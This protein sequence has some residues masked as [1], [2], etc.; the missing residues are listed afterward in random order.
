[1][2]SIIRNRVNYLCNMPIIRKVAI[3][4]NDPK[5]KDRFKSFEKIRDPDQIFNTI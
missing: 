2:W 4:Q 3:L 1:M 5:K